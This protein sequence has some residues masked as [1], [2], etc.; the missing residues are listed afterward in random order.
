MSM[1]TPRGWWPGAKAAAAPDPGRQ[2]RHDVAE[3]QNALACKT[4]VA[5]QSLEEV[6]AEYFRLTRR[7]DDD[8]RGDNPDAGD[9]EPVDDGRDVA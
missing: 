2:V 3:K 4:D 5:M 8:N 7:R 9:G 6:I 1:A